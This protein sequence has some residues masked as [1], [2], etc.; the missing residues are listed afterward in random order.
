MLKYR[1]SSLGVDGGLLSSFVVEAETDDEAREIAD[2][3]LMEDQRDAVEVW[4][5]FRMV[6]RT[7]RDASHSLPLIDPTQLPRGSTLTRHRSD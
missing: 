4:N 7:V 1:I 2:A 6:Y 5:L 3:V